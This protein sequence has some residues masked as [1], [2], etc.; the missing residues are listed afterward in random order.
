MDMTHSNIMG[1]VQ[2]R[3][4]GIVFH[5]KVIAFRRIVAALVHRTR[6]SVLIEGSTS[7]D[8]HRREG[9]EVWVLPASITEM[10]TT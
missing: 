1:Y 7:M 9:S 8:L 4:K 3:K 5:S 6:I 10:T 2:V